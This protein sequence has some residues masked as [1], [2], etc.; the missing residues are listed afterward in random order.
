MRAIFIILFLNFSQICVAQEKKS[1]NYLLIRIQIEYDNSNKRSFYVINAEDGCDAAKNIFYSL[2]KYNYKKSAINND[3]IFYYNH[4][5]TTEA[6]YNYFLS[7]PEA[8]NFIANN[9][10]A[11]VSIYTETFSGSDVAKSANGEF[12]ITTVSSRPVFCF[13]K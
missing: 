12:P 8:L 7:T 2:K 10:F 13:K 4:S 3:G 6:L 9:G 1:T 11:L 5:D